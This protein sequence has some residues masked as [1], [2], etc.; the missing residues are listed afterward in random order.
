MK[1]KSFIYIQLSLVILAS[2][3]SL[4]AC[5]K[6]EGHKNTLALPPVQMPNAGFSQSRISSGIQPSASVQTPPRTLTKDCLLEGTQDDQ[7]FVA[8]AETV[9]PVRQAQLNL[10]PQPPWRPLDFVFELLVMDPSMLSPST[11]AP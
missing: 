1:L 8:P 9:R 6:K 3:T 10:H 7:L 4:V 5:Q 2:L 11:K